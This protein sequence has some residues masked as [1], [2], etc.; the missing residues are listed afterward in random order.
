MAVVTLFQVLYFKYTDIAT[1]T[2]IDSVQYFV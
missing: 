1:H 2:N